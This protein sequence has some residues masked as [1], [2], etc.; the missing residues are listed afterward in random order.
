MNP[1]RSSAR[2]LAFDCLGAKLTLVCDDESLRQRLAGQL[3]YFVTDE[4]AGEM[5]EVR[6]KTA[7]PRVITGGSPV[8]LDPD[9]AEQQAFGLVFRALLDRIDRF[10]VLHA[11]ALERH[12]RALVLAGPSGTG[13]TTLALALLERGFRML[14]D[15]FTPLERETGLVH[16][17]P[18]AIGV[19]AGAATEL[20][21]AIGLEPAAATARPLGSEPEV[22]RG[23]VG[24]PVPVGA[25]VL[26]G[27]GG[28]PPDPLAPYRFSIST[29][30]DPSPILEE[31]DGLAGIGV[32]DSSHGETQLRIDPRLVPTAAL[33]Q[34]LDRAA[35][36]VLSYGVVVS[37]DS[38]ASPGPI[39]LNPV[40]PREALLK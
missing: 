9:R 6:L 21:D 34:V 32:L 3:G 8:P 22:A 16:P 28:A 24:S 7:T 17:F 23:R 37:K 40:P 15:D 36:H 38:S 10:V 33:E 31:V 19:R 18:R 20:A 5:I 30:G 39:V 12:R 26:L 2:P 29:V 13:K 4:V 35:A 11:A 1:S 14:S 27:V 25:I